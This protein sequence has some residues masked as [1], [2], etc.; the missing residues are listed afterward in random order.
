[1]MSP[2]EF[3]IEMSNKSYEELLEKKK[4][5]EKSIEDFENGKIDPAMVAM[6]PSPEVIYT[7][8]LEYLSHVCI[9]LAHRFREKQS[10][11]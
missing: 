9:L 6:K 7:Y 1:M 10:N 4:E 5:L 8:E 2:E 3:G 11:N